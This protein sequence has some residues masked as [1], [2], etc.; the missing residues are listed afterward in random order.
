MMQNHVC[1][2]LLVGAA[3]GGAFAC[4]ESSTGT[5]T[6]QPPLAGLRY[7]NV[8]SDTGP[9]DIRIVDVLVDAPATFGAAF[10]T[11]GEW[12]GIVVHAIRWR[13]RRSCCN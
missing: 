12:V 8:V 4:H 3:A 2:V 5:P 10:R 9:L 11:G 7:V 6:S 1:R 13:G